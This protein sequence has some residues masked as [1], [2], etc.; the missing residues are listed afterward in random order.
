MAGTIATLLA[1]AKAISMVDAD[2]RGQQRHA[3]DELIQLQGV[4]DPTLASPYVAAAAVTTLALNGGSSGSFTLTFNFP[5]Q[6]VTA[7]TANV[8]FDDNEAAIQTL[9]DTAMAGK[10]VKAIYVAGH[11]DAGACVNT[12]NAAC[13]LT[14]NGASVNQAHMVVTTANVDLDVAKPTVAVATV[15]TTVRS[16]EAMFAYY[17]CLVPDSAPLG[18]GITPT[19][20]DYVDGDNPLSLSP[21]L[22]AL[23]VTEMEV[24]ENATLGQWFR[25]QIGCVG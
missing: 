15:G 3:Y 12:A 19:E 16:A 20:D 14:A 4:G 13:D 21:G 24:S 2:N 6:G 17:S 1:S 7:T 18:Y 8:A 5:E 25:A 22:K 23:I 11:L 9:I 10:T